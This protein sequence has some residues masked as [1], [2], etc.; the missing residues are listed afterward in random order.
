MPSISQFFGVVIYMYFNDH[1]PSHFHAEYGEYE[2]VYEIETLETLR[3]GL[4]LRA[5]GMVLEWALSHR[6]ELRAN[7]ERAREQVPLEQVA[8]LD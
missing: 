5:N 4:P 8:P 2:A 3:G 1:M 6:A 7:W